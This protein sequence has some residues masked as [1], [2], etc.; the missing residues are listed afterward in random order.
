M[1]EKE[2]S[3]ASP[4]LTVAGEVLQLSLMVSAGAKRS[5]IIGLYQESLKIRIAAPAVDGAANR[6]VIDF[7]AKL[8]KIKKS[9][10][11]ITKGDFN[12][13]KVIAISSQNLQATRDILLAVV[14]KLDDENY[15]NE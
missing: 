11:K 2:N 10:L 3:L 7:F 12:K 6:A 9:S 8:L 1:S 4:W 14:Q 5:E 13:R 15:R